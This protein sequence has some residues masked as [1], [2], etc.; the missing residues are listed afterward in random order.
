[1]EILS[2]KDSIK[3]VLSSRGKMG[4]ESCSATVRST[5]LLI[6]KTFL[7][8][9]S[10]KHSFYGSESSKDLALLDFEL[11]WLGRDD[12]KNTVLSNLALSGFL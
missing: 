2:L 10:K 5:C 9:T 4:F 8:F 12:S 11:F 6:T 7:P 1:M 3:A